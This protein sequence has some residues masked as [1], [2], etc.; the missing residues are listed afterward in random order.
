MPDSN[1][2]LLSQLSAQAAP[3][4]QQSNDDL[5]AMLNA[6]PDPD[7]LADV[8]YTGDLAEDS[9]RELNAVQQG[10]RD[11]AKRE[12]ERFRLA[13]DSEYWV[14]VCFKSR[15]DKEKFLRNAGLLAIGDKYMDGYAVARV[16][17]VEM[18]DE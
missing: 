5:L 3:S 2:D 4:D 8:E 6:E 15:E 12:A 14:A 10:F 18:D 16:L 11:R 7:P 9:R 1:D 17:G 13:T